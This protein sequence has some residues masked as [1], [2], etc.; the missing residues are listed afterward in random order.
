VPLPYLAQVFQGEFVF[1]MIQAVPIPGGM[2]M[3]QIAYL[4]ALNLKTGEFRNSDI[5]DLDLSYGSIA[6][7]DR[8]WYVGSSEI[9]G[10]DGKEFV[11]F[12]PKRPLIAVSKPFIYEGKL[13]LIDHDPSDN[14]LLL[15]LTEGEWEIRGRVILP[16]SNRKWTIDEHSGER[17]LE[18]RTSYDS[19]IVGNLPFELQVIYTEGQYHLFQTE[20][21]L[22]S[23]DR[24][25]ICYR[26]GFEF[27]QEPAESEPV[28]ALIPTN[29]PPESSGWRLLDSQF[30]SKNAEIVHVKN[31]L[32]ILV[33]STIW[34]RRLD[35]GLSHAARFDAIANLDNFRLE[36]KYNPQLAITVDRHS[37]DIL[38]TG[39]S[40][41]SN[42]GII[43]LRDEQVE[44]LPWEIEGSLG[45]LHDWLIGIL[46][47]FLVVIVA[48]TFA[49]AGLANWFAFNGYYQYGILSTSLAPI[50]R[51]FGARSVD[52]LIVIGPFVIQATN[53]IL[54]ALKN[55][56]GQNVFQG[57]SLFED[58]LELVLDCRLTLAWLIVNWIALVLLTGVR[59]I[60]IGKWLFGVRVVRST[61]RP[62]GIARSL[63]RELLLW[64][65]APQLL[66][67]LPGLMCVIA[68]EN[69]QRIG[70]LIADTIMI[71]TNRS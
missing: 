23:D 40:L 7:P 30:A 70:D 4:R 26:R 51:R 57:K 41:V 25:T 32:Y 9:Y 71:D 3:G 5:I 34:H 61:L 48:G 66:T 64:I 50:L 59:G 62:C 13:A 20:Y 49:M 24:G 60:T 16:G 43:R 2:S 8:I 15:V 47:Q 54:W 28:S 55:P 68:T 67:A 14:D 38:V 65:D 27:V 21:S 46:W 31:E 35:D 12:K 39:I 56:I 22:N 36:Q 1:P 18:P 17:V 29:S 6:G 52:L 37:G 53:R 58:L 33:D 44:R 42:G 19:S 10:W 63:L 45:Y 69:R 11:R